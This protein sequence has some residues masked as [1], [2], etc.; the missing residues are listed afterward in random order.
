M[1]TLNYKIRW[2]AGYFIKSIFRARH[3]QNRIIKSMKTKTWGT[4]EHSVLIILVKSDEF[5]NNLKYSVW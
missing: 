2:F 1:T 5:I 3:G 4:S